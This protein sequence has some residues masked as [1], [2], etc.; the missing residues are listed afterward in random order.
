MTE[1]T[2]MGLLEKNAAENPDEIWLR[3]LYAESLNGWTWSEAHSEIHAVASWLCET[4]GERGARASILSRNCAHWILADMAIIASG[5]VSVPMFTT[6]SSKIAEY[7]FD[8]ADVRV[9]FVGEA[10]NWEALE[11]I[12]PDDM[13]LVTLPGVEVTRPSIKWE[14]LL[15]DYR[16][17]TVLDLSSPDDLVSI[18]FTSGTTGMPKG[19]M[20]TNTSMIYPVARIVPICGLIDNPRLLS[21]L[22]LSHIAERNCVQVQSLV[23]RGQVSFVESLSTLI[24]DLQRTRPTFFFGAPR[25]WESLQQAIFQSFGGRAEYEAAVAEDKQQAAKKARDLLGFHNINIAMSGSAPISTA[26]LRFYDDLGVTLLEGYGQTEAIGSFSNRPDDMKVGSIGKPVGEIEARISGEGELQLRGFGF[27]TGYYNQKDKTEET[28]VDGWL[29]TG[30]RV[31]MDEDGFYFITGRIKDYFKTIHGKYVAP[32]PIEDQFSGSPFIDQL[33]LIGRGC[34]KT[35]LVCVLNEEARA[36]PKSEIED[37]LRELTLQINAG[38]EE[39]HA[40]IG[41]LMIAADAWT[42]ENGMIT[43]TLKIKRPTIDDNYLER[44]QPLATKAAETKTI[45]VEWE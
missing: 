8:F 40:R 13:I 7:I 31:R 19:V 27:A 29:L 15:E 22:P 12:I 36:L 28:F 34:S 9:L 23:L 20:Q 17:R 32:I 11:P 4:L 16:S 39:K 5:N 33:C 18:I 35:T 43:T 26:L 41:V 42:I 30:D 3:D 25:I 44:V 21:Y 14:D 6:Q 1:A 24:R 45:L 10:D 37:S 38:M 2:M